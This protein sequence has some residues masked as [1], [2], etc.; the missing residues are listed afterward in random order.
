MGKLWMVDKL[1]ILGGYDL[2]VLNKNEVGIIRNNMLY[3]VNIKK[4]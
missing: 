2:I 4:G 3:L 1:G